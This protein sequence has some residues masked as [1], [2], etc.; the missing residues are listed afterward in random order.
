MLKA[1]TLECHLPIELYEKARQLMA[2]RNS[3]M[4]MSSKMEMASMMKI[5]M[6]L[7][8]VHTRSLELDRL[9]DLQFT[10]SVKTSHFH[11]LE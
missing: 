4:E 5:Q 11:N 1:Q 3:N 9:A 7:V 6:L 8:Y 10:Y 2:H